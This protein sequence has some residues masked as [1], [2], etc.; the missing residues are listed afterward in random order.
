MGLGWVDGDGSSA[1][2]SIVVGTV[3]CV[4]VK[5][6]ERLEVWLRVLHGLHV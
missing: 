2:L 5:K 1:G 4:V 6:L 3:S